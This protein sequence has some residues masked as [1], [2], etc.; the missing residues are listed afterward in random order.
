MSMKKRND[1]GNE[2]VD[3]REDGAGDKTEYEGNK[4]IQKR[5]LV[6]EGV[7]GLEGSRH[8]QGFC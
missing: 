1:P 2:P 3:V 4:R 7:L 8:Y 5:K 6:L